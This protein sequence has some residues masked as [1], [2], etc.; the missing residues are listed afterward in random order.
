[1]SA[2]SNALTA[3][4]EGAVASGR[5]PEGANARFGKPATLSFARLLLVGLLH[6]TV[7]YARPL[8]N[9]GL[10]SILGEDEGQD[11]PKD[12]ADARLWIY[13]STALV[14]VLLGG[15]FAGLTIA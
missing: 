4:Q 5:R 13:L 14:L 6:T 15:V 7:T 8:A 2:S 3:L 1:M 11:E 9:F 10:I 12:P